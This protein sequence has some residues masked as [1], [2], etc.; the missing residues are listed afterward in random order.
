MPFKSPT[1]YQCINGKEH[2]WDFM[3]ETKQSTQYWCE[4]CGSHKRDP[5]DGQIEICV[6]SGWKQRK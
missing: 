4:L 5:D 2:K 1:I 3:A 6:P